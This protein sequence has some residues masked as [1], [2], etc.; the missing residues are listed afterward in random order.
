MDS[1]HE[2]RNAFGSIRINREFHSNEINENDFQDENHDDSRIS[3]FRGIS[4]D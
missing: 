3:T 1:S 4:I 2:H